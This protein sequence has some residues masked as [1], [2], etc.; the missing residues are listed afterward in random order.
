MQ[1]SDIPPQEVRAI[2]ESLG[3][4]QAEAGKILGGG[5]RAFTKYEAGTV[6]PAVSLVTLL[7]LLKAHP[8]M[9]STLNGGQPVPIRSSMPKPI[10][11]TGDHVS[12]LTEWRLPSLLCRLL[13]AEARANGLPADIHVASNISA[14][15]G[16]EDGRI[17]WKGGPKR[18]FY[19]PARFCQFQLKA[20]AISPAKAAKDILTKS[21]AVKPMVRKALDKN[22]VYIMVCAHSYTQEQIDDRRKRILADVRKAGMS[23][24]DEQIVFRSAE[25]IAQWAND[26]PSIAV[27]ILEL[28]QPGLV[29]SFRSWCYWADRY[30]HRRSPWVK[31]DRLTALRARLRD[32][33]ETPQSVTRVVGLSGIGKSRL[34]L[35]ALGPTDGDAGFRDLVLYAVASKDSEAVNGVVQNHVDAGGRSIVVVDECDPE[36]VRALG[37]T[38]R[39]ANSRLSL[40][41]IE[42]EV[43]DSPPDDGIIKI[44]EAPLS[45]IEGIVDRLSPSLPSADRR[46]LVNFSKGFPKIAFFVC[47][48]WNTNKPL[49]YATDADLAEAFV[50]GL[51]ARERDLTLKAAKLFAAFGVVQFEDPE[52]GSTKEIASLGRGLS[53]EDLHAAIQ[54]FVGRGIVKQ[55]GCY[56]ALQPKLIALMLAERQWRDWSRDRWDYVLAGEISRE[57]K[58]EAAR[59]LTFLNTTDTARNVA[60]HVCRNDGP[61]DGLPGISRPGNSEV[62]SALAEISSDTVANLIERSLDEPDVVSLTG[63]VS[64]HLVLALE[65]VAFPRSTFE[66]GARLLLR[67]AVNENKSWANNATDCFKA[68]FPVVLGKTVAD[69]DLRMN[70]LD[71]AADTAN[72]AQRIIVVEALLEGTRTALFSRAVGAETHGACPALQSWQPKMWENARDYVRRCVEMLSVQAQH[73]DEVAVKARAGLGHELS[74]LV[75]FGLIETVEYVVETILEAQNGYWPEALTNLARFDRLNS[76]ESASDVV[77]RV[78]TLIGKLRQPKNLPARARLL[79]KTGHWDYASEEDLEPDERYER[80]QRDILALVSEL[81]AE[82]ETLVELLPELSRSNS[83][84]TYFGQA[85][86][87]IAPK[88]LDW[89]ASIKEVVAEVPESEGNYELLAG[90]LVGIKKRAPKVLD[91]VKKEVATSPAHA[92]AL[93]LIC[94]R[95]GIEI[96]DISLIISTMKSGRLSPRDLMP[97]ASGRALADVPSGALAPLF[98]MMLESNTE[99]YEVGLGLLGMYTYDDIDR[100]N[101]LRLQILKAAENIGKWRGST[102]EMMGDYHLERIMEWILSKGRD[103]ADAR[104]AAMEFAKGLICIVR[105]GNGRSIKPI[106][107]NL[108]ASFPEIAWTLIG[109]ALVSDDDGRFLDSF[110]MN[111]GD[112]KVDREDPVIMQ[113]PEETLLAWCDAHPKE[114]PAVAATLVPVLAREIPEADWKLHP[115]MRRL[116]DEFGDSE[117]VL[118][119]IRGN[120]STYSWTGSLVPYWERYK[121][122]FEE[123]RDHHPIAKVR[124]WARRTLRDID[125]RLERAREEDLDREA[126][127]EA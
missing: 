120:I 99:S 88:P 119:S 86:A 56:V 104:K 112:R 126:R 6:K 127:W 91:A 94:S 89:L 105:G 50:L 23:I 58:V 24:R 108:L 79:A 122:P 65:K 22:A 61:L 84:G 42:D 111:F 90:F 114:A 62:L 68:L 103:D 30:E 38:V 32:A 7:R 51:R 8:E 43:P 37:D 106:L 25:Q 1:K 98:D 101:D 59:R 107:G 87:E 78:R 39:H 9:L 92:P 40:V 93:P 102:F 45:V 35:Q 121:G 116:L 110:V 95:L 13:H 118:D 44:D 77:A 41:T 97:W 82:P 63:D 66:I 48:S 47:G 72:P 3:L 115:T 20:G 16:G 4:T 80:G 81:V 27:S 69:A 96:R 14:R 64:R 28:L 125:C 85:I 46:R 55:Y 60:K 74:S 2:R 21:G 15:D 33:L 117:G 100:L 31:D 29:G 12:Q 5:P 54:D 71:K 67:L 34:V 73:K 109:Q 57:L 49:A 52:G 123:L 18:T 113:L 83:W 124:T 17:E 75:K 36:T 76:K 53:V 10:E 70:V 19:L 26:H 11:V